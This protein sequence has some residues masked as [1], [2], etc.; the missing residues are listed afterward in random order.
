MEYLTKVLRQTDIPVW[1]SH[2]ELKMCF[3]E[4]EKQLDATKT[5]IPHS[6]LIVLI[7]ELLL[8]ILSMFRN[9]TV[10]LDELLTINLRTVEIFLNHLLTDFERH[11]ILDDMAEHCGLGITSLSK[12]CGQLK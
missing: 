1:K 12:Y 11:W 7:N 5:E 3:K 4:L 9:G 10:E 2:K 8:E 6:R